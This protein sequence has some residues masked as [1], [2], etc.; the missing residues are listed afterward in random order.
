MRTSSTKTEDEWAWE[1]VE[2]LKMGWT[3]W[4]NHND[5]QFFRNATGQLIRT[6]AAGQ[7]LNIEGKFYG[8]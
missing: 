2:M 8:A 4:R 7:W 6:K 3:L 1:E 5:R